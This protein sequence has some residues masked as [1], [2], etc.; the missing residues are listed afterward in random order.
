MRALVLVA[1]V[2][3]AHPA[4]WRPV[5]TAREVTLVDDIVVR[6]EVDGT[7]TVMARAAIEG[8]PPAF[9][10]VRLPATDHAGARSPLVSI[11]RGR[12][13]QVLASRLAQIPARSCEAATRGLSLL[14]S[15]AAADLGGAPRTHDAAPASAGDARACEHALAER[16]RCATH[17]GPSEAMA[18][19]KD[20]VIRREEDDVVTVTAT[21]E[22]DGRY[23]AGY[24]RLRSHAFDKAGS[25]WYLDDIARGRG[26]Q[27]L[28]RATSAE[29]ARAYEAYARGVAA[30]APCGAN[31]G[32]FARHR[33]EQQKDRGLLAEAVS[34]L[35][36]LLDENLELCAIHH[37]ARAL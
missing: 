31:D 27:M 22:L 14:P 12:A 36:A 5:P 13:W 15:C 18:I 7:T 34:T 20:L 19:D 24:V 29:P 32:V 17:A 23:G 33:A 11:A 21:V 9:G 30:T 6:T 10:V 28:G 37:H 26:W 35:R 25:A 16:L 4:V 1:A 8:A 2:A 3:C